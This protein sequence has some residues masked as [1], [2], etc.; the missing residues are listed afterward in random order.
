MDILV[1]SD[2][3]DR[4]VARSQCNLERS[5][6]LVA[7]AQVLVRTSRR[8][9]RPRFAGGSDDGGAVA[10]ST[11]TTRADRTRMKVARGGLPEHDGGRRW[12]GPGTGQR[13]DGCGESITPRETE[14]EVDVREALILRFH[15]AC[16]GAWEA[17]ERDGRDGA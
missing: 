3:F 8:I 2:V 6:L 13:C 14:L 4:V 11:E 16:F 15:R 1:A 5:R 10:P 9:R 17:T 12:V 7:S